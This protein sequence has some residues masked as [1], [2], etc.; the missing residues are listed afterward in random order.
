MADNLYKAPES[1]LALE[2]D[3][4]EIKRPKLVWVIFII[5]L[6]SLPGM[7]FHFAMVNGSF[8][9]DG[10]TKEYYSNIGIIDN[11]LVVFG[12]LYGF[13]A[14][15]Q[16]FRLKKSALQLYIGLIVLSLITAVYNFTNANYMA[17]MQEQGTN[18]YYSMV[19]GYLIMF[20]IVGYIYRLSKKGI[21]KS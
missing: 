8:P 1:E 17:F 12:T 4:E 5:Y 21:L 11:I 18:I 3:V 2:D 9:A 14:A 20:C 15:L 16:L 19:P 10:A 6:I 7:Y 13:I